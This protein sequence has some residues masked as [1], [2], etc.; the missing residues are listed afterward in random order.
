M[1]TDT[2]IVEQLRFSATHLNSLREVVATSPIYDMMADSLNWADE[3]T[4]D[5]PIETVWALRAVRHYRTSLMLGSPA[6]KYIAVWDA[7]VKL[8]PNWVG[9]MTSRCQPDNHLAQ[10]FSAAKAKADA[11]IDKLERLIDSDS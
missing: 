1:A 11:E 3:T 2:E 7:A 6:E 10:I 8:F 9:F 5:T 4:H